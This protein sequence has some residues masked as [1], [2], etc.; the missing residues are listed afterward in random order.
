[1]TL[2]RRFG[3]GAL[4]RSGPPRGVPSAHLVPG[5]HSADDRR[6]EDSRELDSFLF[7]LFLLSLV[8]GRSRL[9][10][11]YNSSLLVKRAVQAESLECSGIALHINVR[12]LL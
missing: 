2:C 11:Q 7:C 5:P 8:L 6:A 3:D 9:H 10:I 12:F 1:M 4:G